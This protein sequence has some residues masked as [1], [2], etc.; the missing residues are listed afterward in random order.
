[1]TNPFMDRTM[2]VVVRGGPMDIHGEGI[3][4]P[5]RFELRQR[6]TEPGQP[7]TGEG[8]LIGSVDTGIQRIDWLDGGYL[9]A[10]DDFEA[11][12]PQ[13]K[14]QAAMAVSPGQLGH[15]TFVAG[16]ALQQAPAAGVWVERALKTTGDATAFDVSRAA[17]ELARRRVHVLNLSLGC[18]ADEP[19]AREVMQGVVDDLLSINS[20]M[21]IVAAA[22]NL[23]PDEPAVSDPQP[24]WPAALGNVV[25]VGAVD[26]PDSTTWSS[27]SNRGPWV[28]L[29]A[30]A[31]DLLS[32][33][34]KGWLK[35]SEGKEPNEYEGWATWSGTSFAAAVV[36]GAIA[37][38]MT[39]PEPMTAR[40]AVDRLRAGEY[41]SGRTEA[42]KTAEGD[43][44]PVPIVTLDTWDDQCR[45]KEHCWCG[46]QRP[47]DA[48]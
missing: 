17:K 24:F 15:G 38:L 36:S 10:P 3:P 44:P 22:G 47:A 12:V 48:A 1:M 37:R 42:G 25:A 13:S 19:D 21:V 20:D 26:R 41:S 8:V 28:N 46:P 39:G 32:T 35:T 6:Q 4:L 5:S 34:V 40:E 2:S 30:P 14:E 23:N 45:A 7:Y 33:F 9:S 27:W 16:L 18:Y 43:V 11:L 31:D 29:A